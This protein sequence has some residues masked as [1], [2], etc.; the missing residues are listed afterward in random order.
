[1]ERWDYAVSADDGKSTKRRPEDAVL[2]ADAELAAA[3]SAELAT[4]T[5]LV[6]LV[7]DPTRSLPAGAHALPVPVRPAKLRA[8]LNQ[9]QKTLSKSTP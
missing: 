9:L 4:G 3:V 7:Q 1:M 5:P 6:V 8:L 2:I